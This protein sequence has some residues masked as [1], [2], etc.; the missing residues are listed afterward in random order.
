MA[1]YEFRRLAQAFF[2][3]VQR[4]SISSVRPQRLRSVERIKRG[5]DRIEL[6][7]LF[8]FG[9]GLFSM[10]VREKSRAEEQ[11]IVGV[12]RS[13]IHGAPDQESATAPYP[14]VATEK[15]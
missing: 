7:G 14:R 4:G 6:D 11:K 2:G 8:D 15:A 9:H 13:K 1:R 12:A 5:D 10:P 3:G